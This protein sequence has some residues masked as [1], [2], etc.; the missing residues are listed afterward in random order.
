MQIKKPKRK[1]FVYGT[2]K[3][4][5]KNHHYVHTSRMVADGYIEGFVMFGQRAN[6]PFIMKDKNKDKRVFGE[7]YDVTSDVWDNIKNLEVGYT[8][9]KVKVI[10]HGLTH[11]CFVYI[12]DDKVKIRLYK[13]EHGFEEI[14]SGIWEENR[15]HPW[16]SYL[17]TPRGRR[18]RPTFS[19]GGLILEEASTEMET[20]DEDEDEEEQ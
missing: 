7:I 17:A 6:F 19:S 12:F 5:C 3:N 15:N 8:I 2:L 18:I 14:E 9:T 10:T 20:D 16:D 11:D 1:I 4:T 13:E